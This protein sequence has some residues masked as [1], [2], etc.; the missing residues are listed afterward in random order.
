MGASAA[1]PHSRR[2]SSRRRCC[3]SGWV[4]RRNMAQ[5]RSCEVVSVSTSAN[6][7]S[8]D[9]TE[10]RGPRQGTRMRRPNSRVHGPDWA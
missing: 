4:P 7:D 10:A 8:K 3:H 6:Y 9:S 5:V 2:T 1:P